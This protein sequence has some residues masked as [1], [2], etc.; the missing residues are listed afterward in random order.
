MS[1]N[2]DTARHLRDQSFHFDPLKTFDKFCL[3]PLKDLPFDSP[4]PPRVSLFRAFVVLSQSSVYATVKFISCRLTTP[5]S[6]HPLIEN[7]TTILY[8]Q[9]IFLWGFCPETST[10]NEASFN[11]FD[12]SSEV[13]H[14][15]SSFFIQYRRRKNIIHF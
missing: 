4:R 15:I 11:R 6:S 1:L 3:S 7:E 9:R 12:E 5:H 10:I 8:N 2:T 14:S 13:C